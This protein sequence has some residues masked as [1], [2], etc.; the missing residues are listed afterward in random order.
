MDYHCKNQLIFI[1]ADV[2]RTILDV[3]KL[4]EI[5]I[6]KYYAK[7]IQ[8]LQQIYNKNIMMIRLYSIEKRK[9][10]NCSQ[11]NAYE[12]KYYSIYNKKK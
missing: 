9:N 11:D 10:A 8:Q 3:D 7:K 12:L 2:R 1:V 6:L 5:N 4:Y